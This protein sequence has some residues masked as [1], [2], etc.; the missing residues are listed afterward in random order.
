MTVPA[1]FLSPPSVRAPFG[2]YSHVARVKAD[3]DLLFLSGQVGLAADDSI[4][5][6]IEDQYELTV[7][8]IRD[9]LVGAGT[10]PQNIV[11]LT[12]YVVKPI[13]PDA[14][15][16]LRL[17]YLGDIRPAATLVFVPRLADEKLLVEVEAIAAM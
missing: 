12:T 17:Q 11:K 3:A 4:P 2:P 5:D 10:S 7:K 14:L 9:I 1:T 16:R 8:T 15:R 6:S 13:D